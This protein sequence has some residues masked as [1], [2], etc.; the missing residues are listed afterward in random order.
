MDSMGEALKR[1]GKKMNG[2]TI[3]L[4]LDNED[5]GD[6]EDPGEATEEVMMDGDEEIGPDGA[7]KLVDIAPEVKDQ[8]MPAQSEVGE[9]QED[10]AMMKS[11]FKD[12]GDIKNPKSLDQKAKMAMLED[13]KKNGKLA[14]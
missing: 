5:V 3:K 10:M 13:L 9:D 8:S 2:V 14:K 6:I 4:L 1:K 12:M 7:K 11:M